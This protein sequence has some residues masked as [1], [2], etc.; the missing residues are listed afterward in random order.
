MFSE[1]EEMSQFVF[2]ESNAQTAVTEEK[3][4]KLHELGAI[5]NVIS[6]LGIIVEALFDHFICHVSFIYQYFLCILI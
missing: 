1:G 6:Y 3:G 5:I 4:C 2:N